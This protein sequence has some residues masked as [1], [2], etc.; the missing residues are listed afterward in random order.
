MY[1]S[2]TGV[3]QNF[4]E[5]VKWYKKAAEAGVPEAQ[6]KLAVKYFRGEGVPQDYVLA[7]MW[8]NLAAATATGKTAERYMA[9]RA[10]ITEKMTAQDIS[11]AQRLAREWRMKR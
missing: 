10:R 3:P 2:G 11:E 8:S 7:H 9:L 5:A 1:S 6:F 4:P